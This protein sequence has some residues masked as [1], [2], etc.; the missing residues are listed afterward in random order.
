V[1]D[2]PG[3]L[4]FRE[5]CLSRILSFEK[6]KLRDDQV[7]DRVVDGLAEEDDVVFEESE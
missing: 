7:R 6:Q 5:R 2:P 3:E 1:I 4:M